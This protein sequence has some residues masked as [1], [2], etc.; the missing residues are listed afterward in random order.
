MDVRKTREMDSSEE[1]CE[2][3]VVFAKPLNEAPDVIV[4]DNLDEVESRGNDLVIS[5]GEKNPT[6]ASA[7]SRC[8]GNKFDFTGA[9]AQSITDTD[10]SVPFFKNFLIRKS[11]DENVSMIRFAKMEINNIFQKVSRQFM[12]DTKKLTLMYP[13]KQADGCEL[14]VK[15][16]NNS[17]LIEAL[18]LFYSHTEPMST[19]VIGE[20]QP[21]KTVARKKKRSEVLFQTFVK[22]GSATRGAYQI[23]VDNEYIVEAYLPKLR[24]IRFMLGSADSINYLNPGHFLCPLVECK[25]LVRLRC[26]NNLANIE[27]HLMMHIRKKKNDTTCDVLLKRYHFLSN[28]SWMNDNQTLS[29]EECIKLLETKVHNEE[30]LCIGN[31]KTLF[32]VKKDME[33]RRKHHYM[34]E[35][36]LHKILDH[37]LNPLSTVTTDHVQ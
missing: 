28:T 14:I 29:I 9:C 24:M 37:D 30:S 16:I 1:D 10:D 5:A 22:F 31:I 12:I 35:D 27:E 20:E 3:D 34:N 6:A 21:I 8:G 19:L 26:F 18:G 13:I 23:L 25:E 7:T 4:V 11:S 17:N 36:V 33:F 2:G 15:I 32:I